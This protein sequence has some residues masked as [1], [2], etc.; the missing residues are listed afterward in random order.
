V[1][2]WLNIHWPPLQEDKP[3]PPSPLPDPEYHYRVYL[4]DGRQNAGE[5]LKQGDYVFIYETKTGRARKGAGKY[6]PGRQGIIALVRV[7]TP[8][9]EKP[10]EQPEEYLDGSVLWWK[11]QARSQVRQLGFCSRR[12]VCSI[13]GY[14]K[15]YNFRGYGEARSG[16][17]KL[18]KEQFDSLL[19]YFR[20]SQ[21]VAQ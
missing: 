15:D 21:Y 20:A 17:R 6:A 18:T 4:P 14:S 13:L 7:L 1:N 8:I 10:D 16:L 2:Y 5:D 19:E 9:M 12:D 3:E 11:W